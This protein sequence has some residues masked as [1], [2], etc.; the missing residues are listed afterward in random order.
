MADNSPPSARYRER[1]E[2]FAQAVDIAGDVLAEV[3]EADHLVQFGRELKTLAQQ[4]PQTLA[5]LRHLEAALLTY[6]NQT[7]GPHVDRFW[8]LIADADLPYE[9]TDVIADVLKR[10]NIRTT[11]EY[12][13]V[14]DSIVAGQQVGRITSQQA[15]LLSDLIGHYERRRHN[16]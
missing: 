14:V 10:G 1:A 9:R 7:A 15:A 2:L 16:R 5:G 11:A 13:I 8:R 12:E 3:P 6:W 4:P